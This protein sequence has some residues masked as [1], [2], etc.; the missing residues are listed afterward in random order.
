MHSM[1]HQGL[2]AVADA[3][4]SCGGRLM[5]SRWSSWLPGGVLVGNTYGYT[6]EGMSARQFD[7]LDEMCVYLVRYGRPYILAGDWNMDP[8]IIERSGILQRINGIIIATSTPT[9]T[10]GTRLDYFIIHKDLA[11]LVMN[12]EVMMVTG[13][14]THYPVRLRLRPAAQASPTRGLVAPRPFPR[15]TVRGCDLPS[16]RWAPA[17]ARLA[18]QPRF[19]ALEGFFVDVI[20]ATEDECIARY[21]VDDS[22]GAY[23]GRAAPVR[24]KWT[25]P[26]LRGSAHPKAS[27]LGRAWR[28]VAQALGRL[29]AI[30]QAPST[31]GL[32]AER[33][34]ILLGLRSAQ[35]WKRKGLDEEKMRVLEPVPYRRYAAADFVAA[36][37]FD[38]ARPGWRFGTDLNGRGYYRDGATPLADEVSRHRLMAASPVWHLR[39]ENAHLAT[40]A[41]LCQ[42]RLQADYIASAEEQ[43]WANW[44]TLGWRHWAKGAWANGASAAHAFVR[45]PVLPPP[46]PLVDGEALAGQ[47]HCDHCLL[48]WLQEWG[49]EDQQ[50]DLPAIDL[51]DG[52]QELAID[53]LAKAG[54]TFRWKTGLGADQLH[55]KLFAQ[56]SREALLAWCRFFWWLELV[57]RLPDALNLLIIVML[58]KPDGGTRPIGLL[59]GPL[60][61]WGRARRCIAVAWERAWRR[62]HFVACAGCSAEDTAWRVAL[63]AESARA[64]GLQSAAF[65]GDLK[66]AYERVGHKKLLE[67]CRAV[68]FSL[69]LLRLLLAVYGGPR[70]VFLRGAYSRAV[71]L[72][73][74]IVAGC[75]MATTML[76]VF[77]TRVLDKFTAVWDIPLA[78]YIDDLSLDMMGKAYDLAR[79]LPKAIQF[80]VFL[81]EDILEL[82][83]NWGKSYFLGSSPSLR[84]ALAVAVRK[85]GGRVQASGVLLGCDRS[86]GRRRVA[87]RQ[88]QRFSEAQAPE[89]QVAAAAGWALRCASGCCW[90]CWRLRWRQAW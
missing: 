88:R 4:S 24:E 46:S 59:L 66:K 17:L 43:A 12:V 47:D 25:R 48:Q 58:G 28:G 80:L 21:A 10:S 39:L 70:R 36:E 72:S 68:G 8:N 14:L 90:P 29:L 55:P 73:A 54:N 3:P 7:L 87:T 6:S 5:F 64:Q 27:A 53:E 38:S 34:G 89:A 35:P 83:V 32:L 40:G 23:R 63:R 69:R 86:L 26:R 82:V 1:R 71:T 76:R 9:T 74:T 49:G 52:I 77:L 79:Q 57:G 56:F 41:L 67:E 13:V 19:E 2:A 78:V 60:R 42:W 75:T 31:P 61:V 44:K 37:C 15:G 62:P 11:S 50:L 20:N 84:R 65:L 51:N 16:V 33:Q 22:V 45:D 85:L 18:E 30:A 81:L